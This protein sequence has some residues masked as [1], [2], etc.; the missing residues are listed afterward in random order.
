MAYTYLNGKFY[1]DGIELPE[2]HPFYQM[3]SKGIDPL[4]KPAQN[5]GYNP[6]LMPEDIGL[7]SPTNPGLPVGLVG[8]PAATPI[9]SP[10]PV[11]RTGEEGVY[12]VSGLPLS[13]QNPTVTVGPGETLLSQLVKLGQ[14]IDPN[15]P[16]TGTL[17]GFVQSVQ[18]PQ[19]SLSD[20]VKQGQNIVVPEDFSQPGALGD[21]VRSV[22]AATV[23]NYNLQTQPAVQA[24]SFD[25]YEAMRKAG[26]DQNYISQAALFD[27]YEAMQNVGLNPNYVPQAIPVNK[28]TGDVYTPPGQIGVPVNI[29][30]TYPQ[31][32]SYNPYADWMTQLLL[33]LNGMVKPAQGTMENYVP[34]S[35]TNE[36]SQALQNRAMEM[37]NRPYGYTDAERQAIYDQAL[38]EFNMNQESDLEKLKNLYQAFGWNTGA[39]E[40]GGQAMGSLNEYYRNRGLALSDIT[41]NIMKD[42]ADRRFAEEQAA[43]SNARGINADLYNQARGDFADTLAMM[44]FN[45]GADNQQFQ[46]MMEIMKFMSSEEQRNFLNQQGISDRQTQDYWMAANTVYNQNLASQQFAAQQAQQQFENQMRAAG[47]DAEQAQWLFQNQATLAQLASQMTQQEFENAMTAAG[48]SAA[49]AQALFNNVLGMMQF[50]L[51]VDNQKFQQMM[52][53]MRFMSEEE[54]RNFLNQQGI[55]DRET[56]DYWMAI[57][58]AYNQNLTSQQFAAQQAQQQ[59]ENQM[60]AAGFDAEQAQWLFQNQ[61]TLAQLASQMT[62]QEFENTMTAAG[63]SAAQAQALFNNIMNINTTNFAQQVTAQQLADAGLANLMNY[64]S[65]FE[66][67]PSDWLNMIG[68]TQNA[69]NSATLDA[70]NAYLGEPG[71]MNMIIPLLA[72]SLMGSNGTT[73]NVGNGV[74]SNAGNIVQDIFEGGKKVGELIWD[75]VKW[76]YHTV[77]GNDTTQTSA[78]QNTGNTIPT[79]SVPGVSEPTV[80]DL[81]KTAGDLAATYGLYKLGSDILK[82]W[83]GKDKLTTSEV[84]YAVWTYLKNGD[85]NNAINKL[86]ALDPLQREFA[87]AAL[88]EGLYKVGDTNLAPV[89]LDANMQ[90]KFDQKGWLTQWNNASSEVAQKF[91]NMIPGENAPPNEQIDYMGA[92]V[93]EGMYPDRFTSIVPAMSEKQY[94]E[95][96]LKFLQS[97]HWT[98]ADYDK[99]ISNLENMKKAWG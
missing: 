8:T 25:P 26:I 27:P 68:Q 7:P 80:P 82:S 83:F 59:F 39:P 84:P 52:D 58:T 95:A 47:F 86:S 53:A 66:I 15:A 29:G 57:N 9:N 17:G 38:A 51:G 99:A 41:T 70:L 96:A 14:T 54:Q 11:P 37:L 33:A 48:F 6:G 62:Q 31:Q 19:Y 88:K 43:I 13:T 36:L 40:L 77:T 65:Q 49:Q 60:K 69:A 98:Q 23:P 75:G 93:W 76:I 1:E 55:S 94:R 30:Y 61:A 78:S 87:F 50:N 2:T 74:G 85:A 32:A 5:Q 97:G 12:S 10:A 21:W 67:T 91:A 92:M 89:T 90:K 63:F 4:Y 45:L 56:Q 71:M 3:K 81:I 24:A 73:A 64:I 44:Q 34:A 72:M 22:Q 35:A 42:I 18:S 28:V 20:I 79:P 16:N 46:Q